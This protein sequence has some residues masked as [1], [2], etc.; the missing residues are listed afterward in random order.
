MRVNK[1]AWEAC[2][3]ELSCFKV[4]SFRISFSPQR[5]LWLFCNATRGVDILHILDRGHFQLS[6]PPLFLPFATSSIPNKL[7]QVFRGN[8]S[9]CLTAKQSRQVLYITPQSLVP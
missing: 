2:L 5:D 6:P 8:L 1:S 3:N 7:Q 9:P 4:V